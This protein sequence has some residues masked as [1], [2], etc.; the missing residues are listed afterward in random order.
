MQQTLRLTR[1]EWFKL[2]R[3]RLPWILL[4][5]ALLVSQL[6]IWINYA[7]YHNDTVQTALSGGF[8]SYSVSWEED[9]SNISL[10]MTCADLVNNR[11][12]SG[13]NQIAP[14]LQERFLEGV[15]EWRDSG[16][17]ANFQAAEEFRKN[18]TLPN[19]I[20]ASVAGFSSLG[21]I[22]IGPLLIMILAASLIASE[23]GWGTLRTVL[24]GGISRWRFLS[25]KVLLLLWLSCGVL[26]V[27]SFV[28]IVSSLAASFASPANSSELTDSGTWADVII[29]LFKALY[30]LLPFI[31]LSVFA[32]V[33]TSS[34]TLG[35]A[36]SVG[37]FIVESIAAP[38]LR[39]SDTLARIEDYLLVQ[40]VHS[41]MAVPTTEDSSDL[42]R[43]SV[44]ILAYTVLFVALTYWVF[45]GRDIGGATGD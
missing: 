11:L 27:I 45:K 18:F 9:T 34:R 14:E 20:T 16:A 10:E 4:A 3:L 25:A 13:F 28:A 23:Y 5:V 43:A 32:T 42:L 30:G 40:S 24:S 38:I 33:L 26:A 6:V 39:L 37:Y 8:A 17:C 31:G 22:A 21:P 19:S 15:E 1:W 12:P 29:I 36:V 41:W 2:R 35:I 44:V 7:A